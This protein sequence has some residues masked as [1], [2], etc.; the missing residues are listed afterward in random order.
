MNS[1]SARADRR[2]SSVSAFLISSVLL[3]LAALCGSCQ[4]NGP[5]PANSGQTPTPGQS[6]NSGPAKPGEG[7][8]VAKLVEKPGPGG[9]PPGCVCKCPQ[10]DGTCPCHS[11]QCPGAV[12]EP[13]IITGGSLTIESSSPTRNF[14]SYL[15]L[16]PN[17]WKHPDL[18]TNP[19]RTVVFI[20][21][22]RHPNKT[23][24]DI[25]KPGDFGNG[26]CPDYCVYDFSNTGAHVT[27]RVDYGS[28]KVSASTE[29]SDGFLVLHSDLPFDQYTKIGNPSDFHMMKRSDGNKVTNVQLHSTVPIS[30]PQ[31]DLTDIAHPVSD[32]RC[33]VVIHY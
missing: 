6:A 4:P 1:N 12:D 29:T 25:E 24:P 11:C 18:S 33:V 20:K 21:I 8:G 19:P 9:C 30:T 7:K 15:K 2:F 17:D 5:Q 27:L 13:V 28:E 26:T 23:D 32:G 22:G 16:S 3:C 31:G 14:N 10:P